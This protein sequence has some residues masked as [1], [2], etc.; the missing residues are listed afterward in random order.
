MLRNQ[1]GRGIS[2]RSRI[3]PVLF[4]VLW[5]HSAPSVAQVPSAELPS[6]G[7]L[8]EQ[9]YRQ[10]E[11][12]AFDTALAAIDAQLA[13]T[14]D[15]VLLHYRGYAL[16]R[17]ASLMRGSTRDKD[18]LLQIFEQADT[19]LSSSFEQ[20]KWPET[21][22]LRATVLGQIIGL[23]GGLAGMRLGP[24]ADGLMQQAIE[25]SA[26][27]PRVWLLRGISNFYKPKLFGGGAAKAEQ[28]L[29][30]ALELFAKG[31]P[32]PPLP[33]WGH[34]ETYVWLGQLYARDKQVTKAQAAYDRALE[35]DPGL[36]WV[37]SKLLPQLQR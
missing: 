19:A 11:P 20:L 15:A 32:A 16:Y 3:L 28:D 24:R 26:D 23:K 37:R 4:A 36:E 33:S 8:L 31:A 7:Q 18:T 21:V 17:K 27:N 14:Q 10:G 6:V 9:A 30:K 35:L 34:A 25:L 5:I 13:Q 29:Q 22:A 12:Q 1:A 2:M